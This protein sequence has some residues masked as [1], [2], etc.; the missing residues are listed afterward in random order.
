M[1][2]CCSK[3]HVLHLTRA[4]VLHLSRALHACSGPLLAIFGGFS[5]TNCPLLTPLSLMTVACVLLCKASGCQPDPVGHACGPPGS[6]YTHQH[7]LPC[8]QTLKAQVGAIA[9]AGYTSVWLPPPSDSVSPQ[10]YLPRDLY[11]LD[12]QYGTEAELRDLLSVMHENGLKAIADIVINHRCA[13]FQVRGSVDTSRACRGCDGMPGQ[14]R[15]GLNVWIS[16]LRVL[17][18]RSLP[19]ARLLEATGNATG[20]DQ[21]VRHAWAGAGKVVRFLGS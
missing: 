18:L 12:S 17:H 4:A 20:I 1:S 16:Q 15:G 13:H 3:L 19:S 5:S 9:D 6:L 8:L 21:G 11:C 10:G 14:A 2:A 7:R